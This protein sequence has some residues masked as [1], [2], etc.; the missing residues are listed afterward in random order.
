MCAVV[1]ILIS[2]VAS[3]VAGISEQFTHKL[4]NTN[5]SI[6][7]VEIYVFRQVF[8]KSTLIPTNIYMADDEDVSIPQQITASQFNSHTHI[9]IL[10][11]YILTY[12]LV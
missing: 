11:R 4:T 1:F 9:Y 7:I 6:D 2:K 8:C 3:S 5:I 10:Y 12:T